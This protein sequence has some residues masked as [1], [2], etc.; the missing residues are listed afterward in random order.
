MTISSSVTAAAAAVAAA[1]GDVRG[2]GGPVAA[3]RRTDGKKLEGVDER[4]ASGAPAHRRRCDMRLLLL[5]VAVEEL[6]RLQRLLTGQRL[7]APSLFLLLS[8]P[9]LAVVLARAR[10]SN[11]AKVRVE[12]QKERVVGVLRVVEAG[13]RS[14]NLLVM[15]LL[16]KL[17]VVVVVANWFGDWCLAGCR[18]AL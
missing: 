9:A 4:A 17:K 6:L 5:L 10:G 2:E 13:A 8:L 14:G 11:A 15:L 16:D 12:M 1:A 7:V 3:R 18:K